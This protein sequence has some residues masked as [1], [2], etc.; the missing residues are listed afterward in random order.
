MIREKSTNFG[1]G[2]LKKRLRSLLLEGDV[3]GV[4][5]LAPGRRRVLAVL[6]S[7][8]YDPDP[9]L[10]ARAVE[11]TGMAADRLAEKDPEAVQAHLRRLHW[12]ISEES[13]GIC[14]RAPE[15]MAEILRRRPV[16]FRDYFPILISL[17]EMMEEED[18]AHFRPGILWALGRIAGLAGG[19][20]CRAVGKIV[21]ALDHPDPLHRGLAV[22][23]LLKLDRKDALVGRDELAED[24]GPVAWKGAGGEVKSTV[25]GILKSEK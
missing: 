25:G 5:R 7:L 22:R 14:L 23:C 18:L 20:P 10:S 3:E 4:A 12:L 15:M 2:S 13:G 1:G 17:L 8:T 16:E 19:I 11:A 6:M 24:D 21:E 9:V